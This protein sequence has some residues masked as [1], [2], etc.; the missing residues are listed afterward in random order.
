MK[1]IIVFIIAA[2]I[3]ASCCSQTSDFIILKKNGKTVKS[4]F[5]GSNINFETNKGYYSVQINIIQ[6]DSL[7]VTQYDV[8]KVPTN[9]GIY[10]LDT[11]ASYPLKFSYKE[12]TKIDND[13]S[14]RFD[15]KASGY[16]LFYGGTLL[17]AVGLGTWLFTKAGTEY[18]ASPSLVIGGAALASIGY[19]LLK[20]NNSSYSIGKKYRLDYIKVK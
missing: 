13:K 3:S 17:T 10:V 20:S 8:R 7:Y 6:R 18:Y 15:I 5:A 9:L 4:F 12:I 2:F 19:L 11:I 1:N 14:K 16:S